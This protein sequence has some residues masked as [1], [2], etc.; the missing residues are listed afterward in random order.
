[1]KIS[2]LLHKMP[3]VC[4]QKSFTI[5]E[6][7]YLIG[8]YF[9]KTVTEL[10]NFYPLG[11]NALYDSIDATELDNSNNWLYYDMK[12]VDAFINSFFSKFDEWILI[13]KAILKSECPSKKSTNFAQLL[14]LWLPGGEFFLPPFENRL[15]SSCGA[16]GLFALKV[17]F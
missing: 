17:T 14:T 2:I 4:N 7:Q 3:N 8:P 9:I 10:L 16:G 11:S 15:Q 12:F 1:M 6:N 13:R 5:C